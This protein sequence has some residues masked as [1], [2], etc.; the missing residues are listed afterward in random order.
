[1]R[2]VVVAGTGGDLAGALVAADALA[3]KLDDEDPAAARAAAG[4]GWRPWGWAGGGAGLLALLRSA[5]C[6]KGR[7]LG[8]CE[9]PA[10]TSL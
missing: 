6:G 10:V 7:D 2:G 1:M 3:A 5:R 8:V 4:H 9:D